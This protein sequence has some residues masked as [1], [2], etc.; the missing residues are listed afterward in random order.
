MTSIAHALR[1]RLPG[2]IALCLG[3]V[4]GLA[5]APVARA[6]DVATPTA[7]KG[8]RPDAVSQLRRE[9]LDAIR[10]QVATWDAMSAAERERIAVVVLKLR[11]VSPEARAKLLERLRV[12]NAAGPAALGELWTK[13]EGYRRM[14]GEGGE[15]FVRVQSVVRVLA[16][17][18]VAALPP[19][20]AAT[21]YD[22]LS[23][24]ERGQVDAAIGG[25]W[26]RRVLE[27]GTAAPDLDGEL[28]AATPAGLRTELDG[29]RAQVRGAG[30][31][32][33]PEPIRRKLAERLL[34][35]RL[36]ALHQAAGPV[37]P[38]E[39]P[40]NPHLALAVRRLRELS[41][42]AFD[43]VVRTVGEAAEGGRAGLTE[44]VEKHRGPE[45]GD[46]MRAASLWR[47]LGELEKKRPMLS[48]DVLE[49]LDALIASI[50]RAL[51]V[52]DEESRAYRVASTM[53]E[54]LRLLAQLMETRGVLSG[55]GPGGRVWNG[56]P[57]GPPRRPRDGAGMDGGPDVPGMDDGPK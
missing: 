28:P 23:E 13:L 24:A 5:S 41:P 10:R 36:V 6:E 49:R 39:A 47:F 37:T 35:V 2:L 8:G 48:G 51:T 26:K 22:G 20:R 50:L 16:S 3:V 52:P 34:T 45:R 18:V 33:A 38:P 14:P 9:E 15:R 55:N 29:L 54:R 57:G 27:E 46:G 42:A 25:A 7:A 11:T 19:A 31:A 44:L 4:A 1:R 53:P 56:R 40:A 43:A 17:A 21:F 12:A 32:Q 30:G